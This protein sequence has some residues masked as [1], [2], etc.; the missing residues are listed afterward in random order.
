MT[1]LSAICSQLDTARELALQGDYGSSNVYMEG[2]LS[3]LKR[4]FSPKSSG[5]KSHSYSDWLF[6]LLES[7][8]RCALNCCI[9][10]T[11]VLTP[12]LDFAIFRHM[13]TIESPREK[14]RW[15][16]CVRALERERALIQNLDKDKRT[17]E[18]TDIQLAS[19]D[20]GADVNKCTVSK[21]NSCPSKPDG[22][23]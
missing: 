5:M 17:F 16:T 6:K 9:N 20:S 23:P 3:Q 8:A 1:G 11:D 22:D 10:S 13:S 12:H 18:T 7:F 21:N 19:C 4:C 14:G 2:V 15:T